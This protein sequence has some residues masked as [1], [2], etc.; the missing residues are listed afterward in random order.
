MMRFASPEW[1]R[2]KRR[3]ACVTR[4]RDVGEAVREGSVIE[5]REAATLPKRTLELAIVTV[6][7]TCD[8]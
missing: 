8:E 4:V 3:S 6:S 2:S 5:L 7:G 1:H